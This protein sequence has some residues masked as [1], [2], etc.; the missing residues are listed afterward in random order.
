MDDLGGP[1]MEIRKTAEDLAGPGDHGRGLQVAVVVEDVVVERPACHELGNDDQGVV[2][3]GQPAGQGADEGGVAELTQEEDLGLELLDR[4]AVKPQQLNL[5]PRHLDALLLVVALVDHLGRSCAQEAVRL[6]DKALG[7]R[8]P[9]CVGGHCW[10]LGRR[11]RKER[12][13][14]REQEP[15][16][17]LAVTP[18]LDRCV[19]DALQ[20]LHGDIV[21]VGHRTIEHRGLGDVVITALT[22]LLLESKR[23]A[24]NWSLLDASHQMG[25][26][27]SDHVAETF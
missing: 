3:G 9:S 15:L 19:P 22:L 5:V 6:L 10:A 26:I 23:D 13:R 17:A 14:D 11:E 12:R 18:C 20:H 8:D 21:E 1:R 24:L 7:C 27:T 2:V 16:L 4:V 25:D